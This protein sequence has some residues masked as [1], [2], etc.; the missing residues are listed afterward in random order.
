MQEANK[1]ASE[2]TEKSPTTLAPD[3]Y[4]FA[5]SSPNPGGNKTPEPSTSTLSVKGNNSPNG[6]PN[7][8]SRRNTGVYI[9]TYKHDYSHIKS[10]VNSG[11]CV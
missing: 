11:T 4:L 10:S 9:P 8:S 7:A 2:A 1:T 6:N 5:A 3:S